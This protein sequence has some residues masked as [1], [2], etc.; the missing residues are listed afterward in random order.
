[1]DAIN[2]QTGP[3]TVA[4]AAKQTNAYYYIPLTHTHTHTHTHTKKTEA[5]AQLPAA[6]PRA[7][8]TRNFAVDRLHRS[9]LGLYRPQS[10]VSCSTLRERAA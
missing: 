7:S 9:L 3:K 5:D 2:P 10:A 1:M 6:W 4:N 8:A